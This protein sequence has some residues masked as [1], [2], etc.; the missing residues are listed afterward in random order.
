MEV[1]AVHFSFC[2]LPSDKLLRNYG[3][4]REQKFSRFGPP[5]GRPC[6]SGLGITVI[7]LLAAVIWQAYRFVD[8]SVVFPQKPPK[9]V[10]STAPPG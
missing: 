6:S 1:T 2:P 9:V 7:A 5:A 3:Q 10:L 8:R 4:E